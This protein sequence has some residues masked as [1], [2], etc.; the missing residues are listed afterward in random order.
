MIKEAINE[1]TKLS[2][3]QVQE[4]KTAFTDGD[5]QVSRLE[6]KTLHSKLDESVDDELIDEMIKIVDLNGDGKID[7]NEFFKA[8]T[9]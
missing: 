9:E 3:K 4:L 8:N 2:E 6:L 1:K 7:F 5:V